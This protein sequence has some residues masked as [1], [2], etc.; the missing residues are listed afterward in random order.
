[1]KLLSTILTLLCFSFGYTQETINATI[2]HDGLTRSYILYVPASYS[3]ATPAPLV[4]NFHGWTSNAN[5]QMQYADFRS[6]AD[7][8]GFLVVHPMGTLDINGQPYWNANWGGTVNDIGFTAA[9][10]D[11]ISAEY[12]IESKRIYSTGMS[13]GGFMS[14]TLACELGDKFA[15]IAS[16]TGTMNL[17]QQNTCTPQHPTPVMEI[18]GTADGTVPY[19]GNTTMKPI[20]DVI[21]YWVDY[22]NTNTSAILSDIADINAFDGSTVE[23]YLYS[24]G[25][26]GVEVE[27]YK[28]INGGHTWPG[29]PINVG[30][31]NHD[32]DASVKIWE[33][34]AKYDVNGKIL[35]ITSV[36]TLIKNETHIYP[37]PAIEKITIKNNVIIEQ[38]TIYDML[39]KQVHAQ[40]VFNKKQTLSTQGWKSGVYFVKSISVDKE[41]TTTKFV[42]K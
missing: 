2:H 6:I 1:M 30:I 23:H 10:I 35:P 4:F 37:N 40:S 41:S 39:G 32:I 8:A 28:V 17:N 3:S 9:L 38:L 22:N 33:F 7:T 36:Q 15:A 19:L 16:V 24:N 18:H 31:T 12:N 13:N 21:D 34:F 14:Y 27:L 26:N 25:D 42:V 20:E 29:A 11:S 5:D